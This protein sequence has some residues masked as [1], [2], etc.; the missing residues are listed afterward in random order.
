MTSYT[1]RIGPGRGGVRV[2]RR[3]RLLWTAIGALAVAYVGRLAMERSG[4]RR[5]NRAARQL[6]GVVDVLSR[7][8]RTVANGTMRLVRR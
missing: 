2:T 8:G 6:G 5:R 7:T 1:R 3:N 4:S